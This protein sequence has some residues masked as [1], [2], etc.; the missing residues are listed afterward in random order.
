MVLVKFS[1]FK[2]DFGLFSVN[3]DRL[4]AAGKPQGRGRLPDGAS[5]GR[6]GSGTRTSS[7][8]IQQLWKP[9]SSWYVGTQHLRT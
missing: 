9:P 3:K 5:G 6:R 8:Q 2:G 7:Q 4:C 1:N